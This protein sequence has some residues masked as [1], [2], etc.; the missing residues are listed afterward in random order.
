[1]MKRSRPS[2]T[3]AAFRG[4]FSWQVIVFCGK[5]LRLY[6]NIFVNMQ[7]EKQRIYKE[8]RKYVV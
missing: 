1:M 4:N 8:N 5:F 6:A 3:R 7:I 2:E